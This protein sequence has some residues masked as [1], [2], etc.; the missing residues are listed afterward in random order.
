M[1]VRARV[2]GQDRAAMGRPGK[3]WVEEPGACRRS[4]PEGLGAWLPGRG[5]GARA[6]RGRGSERG[7]GR[8][9]AARLGQ[10]TRTVIHGAIAS[11][12]QGVGH[13]RSR[14]SA[15]GRTGGHSAL[16]GG[17]TSTLT[18]A[19]G[20]SPGPWS[21]RQGRRSRRPRCRA[22]LRGRAPTADAPPGPLLPDRNPVGRAG[23][24]GRVVAGLGAQWRRAAATV[25]CT[26]PE[27]L[28]VLRAVA[29]S[30]CPAGTSETVT[31]TVSS[32]LPEASL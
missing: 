21:H 10:W 3:G 12:R 29:S 4:P 11:S 14:P 9:G 13:T 8:G 30:D 15:I 24:A 6:T 20:Y 23:R 28:W 27:S 26:S 31:T 19:Q 5:E 18:A 32:R 25:V 22:C 7:G 16:A 17:D 2:R 1:A